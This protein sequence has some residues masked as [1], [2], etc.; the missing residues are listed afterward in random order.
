MSAFDF[1]ARAMASRA[2]GF[3]PALFVELAGRAIPRA[4]DRVH[5]SGHAAPGI[6]AAAY[7]S[8]T[9][10]DEDLLAAHP[11]CVFRTANG[12]IFRLAP[13]AGMITV[14]QAGAAGDGAANDQ[15]AI[16]RAIDYAIAA[17]IATVGFPAA[18]YALWNPVRTTPSTN[19]HAYDGHNIVVDGQIHLKGLW[20]GNHRRAKLAYYHVDGSSRQTGYQIKGG[21]V[22]RGGGVFL[23]G[24]LAAPADYN[25]RTQV[26][27]ED[28][29]LDGGFPRTVF[30]AGAP[31]PAN[32]A[33]GDGWDITD[34]GL[35]VEND[36]YVGDMRLINVKIHRFGGELVYSGGKSGARDPVLHIRE[37]ELSDGNGNALNP[38]ACLTD[39]D[40]VLIE[41]HNLPIEGW[42]GKHGRITNVVVKDCH[43]GGALQ[44]G[45]ADTVS[46]DYYAPMRVDA[47]K[48]PLGRIDLKLVNCVGPFFPGCW[49]TGRIE[50]IDT[51]VAI[52]A[53]PPFAQGVR[54]CELEILLVTDQKATGALTLNGGDGGAGQKKTDQLDLRVHVV[55]TAAAKAAARQ[56]SIAVGYQGSLGDN[57][58]VH[59]T[60][61]PA[62]YPPAPVGTLHDF[63][64]RF[65]GD[66]WYT[67][68]GSTPT[69]NVQTTPAIAVRAPVIV[70]NTTSTNGL[71]EGV[72]LPTAS[73]ARGTEALLVNKSPMVIQINGN[74]MAAGLRAPGILV[75]P[76]EARQRIV[77]DGALW[78]PVGMPPVKGIHTIA[79]NAVTLGLGEVHAIAKFTHDGGAITYTL[80]S[81]ATLGVQIGT[82]VEVWHEG[83]SSFQFA[84]GTGATIA[85]RGGRL[86]SAGTGARL[87]AQ[88]VAANE[89][90]IWGDLA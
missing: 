48:V 52:G 77:F 88:K 68:F 76:P 7:V 40:G 51:A 37:C 47:D 35:W 54:E 83:T 11:A 63:A 5:S 10:C 1:T 14:E 67:N 81:Q 28:L 72:T 60:G 49:L 58:R 85:S 45:K 90:N 71:L 59:L 27:L 44:G 3:A 56:L 38:S 39:I 20:P 4:I 53:N 87:W 31:W 64:P 62:L 46:G 66:L 70:L 79:G 19:V 6:G 61:E 15:P 89:W 69:Q 12:R 57:I 9:L 41:N 23:K 80:P 30:G 42:T 55:R 13:E 74:T 82:A 18:E 33:T 86:A 16:Q 21:Q 24:A 25:D 26:T 65:T 36:R 43:Y 75:L 50:A 17:G 29:E 73:V 34:R 84:A 8:D 22:W 32:P 2:S 78:Q